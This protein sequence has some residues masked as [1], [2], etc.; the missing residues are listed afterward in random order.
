MSNK[1][2]NHYKDNFTKYEVLLPWKYFVDVLTKIYEFDMK[3]KSGSCRVFVRDD[4]RFTADEP[5]NRESF[6]SKQ[7]RQKA[8]NALIRLGLI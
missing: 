4:E 2:L 3:N 6:V 8:I 5:H 7:D 1:K